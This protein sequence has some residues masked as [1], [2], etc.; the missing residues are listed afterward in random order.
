MPPSASATAD[1]HLPSFPSLFRLDSKVA[2]VTGGTRGLGLHAASG[3]LQAGCSLVIVTSRK[4]DACADAAAALNALP[5]LAPGARAVGIAADCSRVA[6]I[7]RL[8]GEVRKYTSHIDILCANAGATWGSRFEDVDEKNGWDKVVDLNVKG[9][10]F[11]IQK[12]TPL[13]TARATAADP[14]RIIITAS[15]AGLGV[16]STGAMGAYSYSASKA[17]VLHLARNLAVELG[18]RNVLVNSIAPGFFMSRMAAGMMAAQGGEEALGKQSPNGRTGRPEDVAGAVVF[19]AS[20]AGG[21]VNGGTVVL[22]GGRM[23]AA[24]GLEREERLE[25]L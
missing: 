17:A 10:F 16:G 18:P 5:N 20:R 2:L 14:S 23:L 8:V 19:L 25:K 22:D 1:A 7:E 6:D 13:L 21:H 12:F 4:A 11:T 3:L 9:V 15:V 24:G